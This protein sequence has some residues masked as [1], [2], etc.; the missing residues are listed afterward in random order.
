[1][2]EGRSIAADVMAVIERPCSLV[3][4]SAQMAVGLTS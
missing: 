2:S 4:L 3:E 1:V